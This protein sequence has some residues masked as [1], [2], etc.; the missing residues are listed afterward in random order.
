MGVVTGAERRS[1]RRGAAGAVRVPVS[2]HRHVLWRG[3]AVFHRAARGRRHG[4]LGQRR[5]SR[6][7]L[8]L[9]RGGGG[10]TERLINSFTVNETYFYR[11]DLSAG[12]PE[13][14]AAAG[15]GGEAQSGRSGADLVGAVRDRRGAVFDRD[16]AAGKLAAGGCLQHR[17]RGSDIDTRV[18]DDAVEGIYGERALSRLPQAVRDRYF[19]A[20]R[21]GARQIIRDL[22]EMRAVHRRQSGG[23]ARHGGA[24]RVR[25]RVL[26]QR[27]DLF[28]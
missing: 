14:G 18:L 21:D 24:W 4:A 10:E 16:L 8:S 17:D 19:A 1:Q 20:P 7:Y 11:E 13:P 2:A 25:Y 22:R 26:P 27:A 5:I 12:L 28:R 15:G 9:L 23:P 3:E 6:V